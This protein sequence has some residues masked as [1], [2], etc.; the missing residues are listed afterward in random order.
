MVT[1]GIAA[2]QS[3]DLG[4]S[5]KATAKFVAKAGSCNRWV[6]EARCLQSS[7]AVV[8]YNQTECSA[9]TC[10]HSVRALVL[11]AAP[12]DVCGPEKDAQFFKLP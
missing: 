1:A 9:K 8:T 10:D 12:T 7:I 3:L 6:I 5:C 2:E 11:R 4:G